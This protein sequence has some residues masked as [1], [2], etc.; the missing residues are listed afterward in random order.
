M[1]TWVKRIGLFLAVNFL[2]MITLS[3][4]MR[5]F[6]VGHYVTAYGLDYR[7]LAVFCLVWGMG[8]S[9]ISLLLSRFMAKSMM[10]VEVIDPN[11]RDPEL[12]NLVH[13]VHTS[14]RSAGLTTMPEVGI[15]DSPDLNAFATGPS[16]SRS[17]VAVSTGLL[18]RMSRAEVEGV[19]G[20]EIAHVANGD[21][22]TLTLIQGVVNAFAMFLARILAFAI[23]QATRSDDE[24]ERG[25][26]GL[27]SFAE[28]MLIQLFEM[29]FLVLG[30]MVVA[31][32]S[33]WRE[34]R[35]DQGGAKVA[36]RE[37]MIAALRKLQL[38][39]EQPYHAEPAP[40]AMQAL[41]IS[42]RKGGFLRLFAS[43]PPLEDRIAA[44]EN[45]RMF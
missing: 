15:Y 4:I 37:K 5:L 26:G 14:A 39:Y 7:S 10:G 44:L 27:G 33:R 11:T 31:W 38:A 19:I 21:M 9:L 30:S 16:R 24:R 20:H 42:N 40:A 29:V 8:G 22:V 1:F 41:Q 12:A 23:S 34:F 28:F 25:R 13:M 36:G 2:V 18:S 45:T 3:F 43:H 35:A 6:G 32:F 17:L